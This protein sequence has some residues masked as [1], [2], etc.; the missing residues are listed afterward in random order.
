MRLRG[1]CVSFL[2]MGTMRFAIYLVLLAPLSGHAGGTLNIY[3]WADYI[4]PE[5]LSAFAH[6]YDVSVNYDIY[7]TSQIV[8]AKL[9]TGNSGY[10]V[11]VH[12]AAN[13]GRLLPIGVF[14]ALD[15][16]RLKN[17]SNLDPALLAKFADFDPGNRYGSPYMWGTTGFS[18]N[19]EMLLERVPQAPLDSAALVF[20]PDVISRFADCGVSL[21]DDGA[22]VIGMALLYLGRDPN[23]V[24]PNDLAKA[25]EVLGRIR[26]YIRYFSSGRLLNDLPSEEICIGMS[27]SGDYAIASRRAEAAGLQLDLGYVVPKEGALM[28]FDVAY[29][30]SDARNL[31]NAYLFLDYL[32]RPEVIADITDFTGYANINIRANELVDPEISGDPA[33]YPTPQ[34]LARLHPSYTLSPKSERQRSRLWT[35]I[36]AGLV[37]Q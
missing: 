19:R 18:Y 23:S 37:E 1:M 29:I 8:D 28:W 34:V 10:D 35:R 32:N 2:V 27:W 20:D 7:D 15:R 22:T 14:H 11:V 4:G 6:E 30:P 17:W 31:D 26:P 25:G 24:D 13:A 12:S 33:I 9:M 5:T 16:S 36:K 21:L 3:N